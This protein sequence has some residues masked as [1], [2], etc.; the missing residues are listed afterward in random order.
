MGTLSCK[1]ANHRPKWVRVQMKPAGNSRFPSMLS[2]PRVFHFGLCYFGP[3][4]KPTSSDCTK[5]QPR[6]SS[7][8]SFLPLTCLE[9]SFSSGARALG[10][11]AARKRATPWTAKSFRPWSWRWS[12]Q[13]AESRHPE[14]QDPQD[15]AIET[16]GQCE[17]AVL[18]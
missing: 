3:T 14:V 7:H 12:R 18:T 10:L 1:P 15:P 9:M 11:Q 5:A 16:R 8:S 2:L 13:R 17:C 6:L 4:N